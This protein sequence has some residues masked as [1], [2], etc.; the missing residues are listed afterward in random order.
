MIKV[1]IKLILLLICILHVSPANGVL[2]LHS[3]KWIDNPCEQTGYTIKNWKLYYN[4]TL[5]KMRLDDMGPLDIYCEKIDVIREMSP[6]LFLVLVLYTL[7]YF[8]FKWHTYLKRNRILR[9]SWWFFLILTLVII[10]L[11]KILLLSL[12]FTILTLQITSAGM[13]CSPIIY[14]LEYIAVLI[15]LIFIWSVIKFNLAP[16]EKCMYKYNLPNNK[17][18][19]ILLA[20]AFFH[21]VH[22]PFWIPYEFIWYWGAFLAFVMLLLDIIN[23]YKTSVDKH[24]FH[25]IVIILLLISLIMFSIPVSNSPC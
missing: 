5:E 17:I 13:S 22:T 21:I 12:L 16:K 3:I 14:Y 18:L 8:I 7:H 25:K 1:T 23:T 11:F 9:I 4:I 10:S 19:F 2:T 6:L 24:T 20:L 15:I